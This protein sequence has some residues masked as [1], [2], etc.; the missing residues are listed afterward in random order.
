MGELLASFEAR[1]AH[2]RQLFFERG[3][4]PAGL[5]SAPT[6]RSWERSLEYGLRTGD[7]RVLTPV[8]RQEA[9]IVTERNRRL[10]ACAQPEMEKLR[11]AMTR[12]SW[13]IVCTD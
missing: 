13:G 8:S 10:I 2:A 5:V 4:N 11:A 3:Q 1:L 7:E 6:I 9:Q 12:G